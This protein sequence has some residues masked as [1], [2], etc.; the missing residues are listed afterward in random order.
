MLTRNATFKDFANISELS[1]L[2]EFIAKW[3]SYSNNNTKCVSLV[4]I[5]NKKPIAALFGEFSPN[6]EI[7]I[8]QYFNFPKS[9]PEVGQFLI[10]KAISK[11]NETKVVQYS[12][13]FNFY[14]QLEKVNMKPYETTYRYLVKESNQNGK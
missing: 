10:N 14:E 2:R 4:T 9:R 7:L 1:E 12:G 6:N 5:E 8:L 3:M 13:L 11:I